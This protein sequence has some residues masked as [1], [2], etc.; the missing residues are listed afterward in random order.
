[1]PQL[2]SKEI[3]EILS[4]NNSWIA[5][6]KPTKGIEHTII[7]DKIVGKKVFIRDPWPINGISKLLVE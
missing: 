3:V 5:V 4:K 2:S 7:I 1:M 6:V